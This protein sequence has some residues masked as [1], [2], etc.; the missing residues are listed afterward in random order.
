[1]VPTVERGLIRKDHCTFLSPPFLAGSETESL[2]EI[3]RNGRCCGA[4]VY[5]LT[6]R[7]G[8][9]G[10]ARLRHVCLWRALVELGN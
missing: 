2:L 1:M 9:T 8:R 7:F 10:S 3:T 5:R 6:V 4:C